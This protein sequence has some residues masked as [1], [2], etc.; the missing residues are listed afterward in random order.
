MDGPIPRIIVLQ[1][2]MDGENPA[3]SGLSIDFMLIQNCMST[4]STVFRQTSHD[5]GCKISMRGV[6]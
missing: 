5:S 2:G 6:V 1:K 4:V 3:V